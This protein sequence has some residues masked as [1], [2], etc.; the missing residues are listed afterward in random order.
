MEKITRALDVFR[1]EGLAGVAVRIKTRMVK[2]QLNV[3]R[4]LRLP[5]V[6][7]VYGPRLAA[8]WNDATFRFYVEGSYG[9]FR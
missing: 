8:N 2:A 1:K 9:F 3:Q 4:L 5:I 7:S 6:S